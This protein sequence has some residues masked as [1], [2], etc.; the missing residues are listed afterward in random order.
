M[1]AGSNGIALQFAGRLDI[2]IRLEMA[3]MN[4]EDRRAKRKQVSERIDVRDEMLD[5]VIGLIGNV[6]ETGMLLLSNRA[7]ADDA[8]FQLRF[9]VTDTAGN[10]REL[11]VGAHQLWS[12]PANSPGQYWTGFRF[13]DVGSDDLTVLRI[14]IDQPGSHYV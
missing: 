4:E 2:Q 14:W 13:I 1:P 6:S 7:M 12:E 8:L 9:T 3:G 11:S 5:A 10:Q